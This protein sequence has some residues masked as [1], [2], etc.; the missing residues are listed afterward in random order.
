MGLP[1]PHSYGQG[2]SGDDFMRPFYWAEEVE[3]IVAEL[4]DYIKKL[5]EG[6]AAQVAAI[7]QTRSHVEAELAALKEDLKHLH[8]RWD[9]TQYW[10]ANLYP[11]DWDRCQER[12]NTTKTGARAEEGGGE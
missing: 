2:T 6:H 4:E 8:S 12:Y 1:E 10:F 9:Y 5:N 7:V 3:D 11:V